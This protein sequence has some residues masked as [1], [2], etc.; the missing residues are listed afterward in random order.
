MGLD[1]NFAT[2]SFVHRL[3]S[4]IGKLICIFK[5]MPKGATIVSFSFLI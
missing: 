2:L 5:K 1:T 3:K 4:I